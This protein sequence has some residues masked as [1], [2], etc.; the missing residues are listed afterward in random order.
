MKKYI[1]TKSQIE[2]ENYKLQN[3]IL[4][5][6]NETL[7]NKNHTLEKYIN[8]NIDTC[9]TETNEKSVQCDL[10]SFCCDCNLQDYINNYKCDDCIVHSNINESI[11][12]KLQKLEREIIIFKQNYNKITNI[13]NLQNE[14][15]NTLEKSQKILENII[16]DLKFE[17]NFIKQHKDIPES[18]NVET[19]TMIDLQSFNKIYLKY[20]GSR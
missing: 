12:K 14:E 1:K 3:S 15:I 8:D 16:S 11:D 18:K 17:N 4:L 20:L 10:N 9:N 13:C 7:K 6:E 5:Q 2:I 19:Q